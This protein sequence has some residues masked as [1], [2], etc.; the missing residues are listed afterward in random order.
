MR[1]TLQHLHTIPGTGGKPGWCNGRARDFFQRHGLDWY[2]FRHGGIPEEAFLATGD[3]LAIR[4]V[5][6]AHE[7]AR[8]EQEA[9]A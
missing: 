1:I 4:L 5:E 8:I 9:Q 2:Q 7:S 6:W 3:G